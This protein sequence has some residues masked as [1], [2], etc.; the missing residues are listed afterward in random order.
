MPAI[1][2]EN[3]QISLPIPNLYPLLQ[4]YRL[5]NLL[6]ISQTHP[7]VSFLINYPLYWRVGSSSSSFPKLTALELT[8]PFS[9][10]HQSNVQFL[11]ILPLIESIGKCLWSAYSVPEIFIGSWDI[12][13]S[14]MGKDFCP[15]KVYI[16]V[17]E[18]TWIVMMT[19][20]TV[21]VIN[22]SNKQSLRRWEVQWKTI[23]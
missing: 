20:M 16:W 19:M 14:R 17:L 8:T 23:F 2:R 11:S 10:L 21:A 1:V 9:S 3:F 15:P 4:S 13:A 12:S 5:K 22:I 6:D 7:K 18:D